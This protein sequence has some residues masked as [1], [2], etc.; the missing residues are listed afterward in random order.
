MEKREKKSRQLSE[1]AQAISLDMKGGKELVK[2]L[3]W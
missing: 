3:G 1:A 2:D